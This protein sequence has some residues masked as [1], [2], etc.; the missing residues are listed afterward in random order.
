MISIVEPV[1]LVRVSQAYSKG[2]SKSDLYDYTRGQWRL[3][4]SRAEKV[5]F[6]ISVF[7]GEVVEVYKILEWLPAGTSMDRDNKLINR[8]QG[9]RIANRFEFIG[10]IANENIRSK[11][12][13]KSVKHL[14]KQ[15]NSNPIMYLNC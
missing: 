10:E 15:G 5:K 4:K 7:Q 12:L 9:E 6:G 3:S 2:M 13:N 1:I 14:F 11:Y 8:K